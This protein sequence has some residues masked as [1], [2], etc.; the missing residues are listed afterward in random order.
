MANRPIVVDAETNIGHG[1]AGGIVTT[2]G[3]VGQAAARLVGRI[4]DGENASTIP[5]TAGDFTRPVFD[6][7]Q[8]QRF[9]I[10]EARLPPESEIRFRVPGIWDQYRWQARTALAVVLIQG[11]L[12]TWL[13]FECRRRRGAEMELRRRLL[14]VMHLNRTA[15]AGALSASFAH[16]LN[17]PLGAILSNA[18]TAEVLLTA[19][20][21]DIG[22]LKDI[23]ADIRRDDQRA[24]EIIRHLGGLLKKKS[25]IDLQ[26][27][28]LNDAVRGTL[29]LLDPEASSRGVVLGVGPAPAAYRYAPTRCTCS[30]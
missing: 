3:P 6:W 18:E 4:L 12:I 21:P 26:E 5:V 17:Q 11:A 7:R 30:R 15:A 10:S 28:D 2:P 8:L 24:A 20:P 1:G 9:G 23:L 16:E 22:Q 13:L 29:N 27:F 25:Q 14:E 19:S